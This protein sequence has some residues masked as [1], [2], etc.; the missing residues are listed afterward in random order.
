M[1][2]HPKVRIRHFFGKIFSS[3]LTF[4]NDGLTCTCLYVTVY[5]SLSMYKLRHITDNIHDTIYISKYECEMTSTPFFFRLHDV[6]QSSTV[7]M[8]LPANR[9]KRYEHSLGT[10]HLAGRMFHAALTNA[11]E[12]VVEKFFSFAEKQLEDFCGIMDRADDVASFSFMNNPEAVKVQEALRG[13]NINNEEIYAKFSVEGAISKELPCICYGRGKKRLALTSAVLQALRLAALFHDVGHPPFS[14]IV[15]E[16]FQEW[17]ERDFKS[18][19]YNVEKVQSLQR[20]L[21]KH[22][23]PD[24]AFHENVGR[25]MTGLAFKSALRSLMGT[26]EDR[27]PILYLY[28]SFV[29]WLTMQ[30]LSEAEPFATSLHHFVD[31][32]ID[33]DRL[34]YIYRDTYN[35]GFL[36]GQLP[37]E[38]V[39]RSIR[40][41]EHE[42][43]LE[44]AFPAKITD[45]IDDILLNRYKIFARINSHHRT[46]RSANLLQMAI[47]KLVDDFLKKGDD[48]I[49][50]EIVHL[51]E[52]LNVGLSAE[53]NRRKIAMWNDSWLMSVLQKALVKLKEREQQ[54]LEIEE[55]ELLNVLDELILNK[56]RFYS[57]LK[58]GHDAVALAKKILA[59]A[60]LESR[61]DRGEYLNRIMNTPLSSVSSDTI[62]YYFQYNEYV[63]YFYESGDFSV[64]DIMDLIEGVDADVNMEVFRRCLSDLAEEKVIT[65]FFIVR[66]NEGRNKIGLKDDRAILLFKPSTQEVSVYDTSNLKSKLQLERNSTLSVNLYVQLCDENNVEDNLNKIRNRIIEK[67]AGLIKACYEREFSN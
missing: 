9:T 37:Y 34:D 5:I 62:N 57:V 4:S 14:H 49:A 29:A 11:E 43:K 6:Y 39:L 52:S 25:K 38:C 67:F 2:S 45:T 18:K 21:E 22:Y 1:I 27:T 32:P 35:S 15:E 20:V 19:D 59:Q 33:A 40:L 46:V 51:W 61:S 13:L 56:K 28:Y 31:G 24:I 60:T 7:Y 50:P 63:Q 23:D 12:K 3:F 44:F 55:G 10:M 66:K 64:L 17:N 42:G 30:I 26:S 65:S 8:T 48:S 41:V 58:R 54:G 16:L 47:R 36:W 53:R